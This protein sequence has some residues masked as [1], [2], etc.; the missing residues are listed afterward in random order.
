LLPGAGRA[1]VHDNQTML[2]KKDRQAWKKKLRDKE[3]E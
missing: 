3:I 1:K 2:H